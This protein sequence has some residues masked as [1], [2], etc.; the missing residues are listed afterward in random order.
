MNT[1]WSRPVVAAGV[2]ALLSALL[3]APAQAASPPLVPGESVGTDPDEEW[4]EGITIPTQGVLPDAE[5][6]PSLYTDAAGVAT[7]RARV[8]GEVP[9]PH[10]HYAMAWGRLVADAD[11]AADAGRVDPA[12][13]VKT[14]AA[15]ATGFAWL[16]TGEQEYLD[17]AAA[18]LAAAYDTIV[19]TDQYV[20]QQMTNYALA[21]DWVAADLSPEQDG[22]IRA[23]VKR[24]ADWLYDYLD[25]P[26][27]RSHNHRSKAGAALGS[28][29]LAFS[30]DPDA[31]AYLDRGLQNINRVFRYMFTKDGI[32]RDGAAYY[33]I[34][35]VINS[36]PFLWQYRNVSGVDLFP[37]LQ[38]AFEWQLTTINPKGLNPPLDDGWYKVTWLN[39]VAA[40][41]ADTPTALSDSGTLGELFQWQFFAS[42]LNAARYP[43]DWTGARDQFY[44]WP[45]EIALYDSTIAEVPPDGGSGTID[46]NA[47]P[48]GGDTI[49][50]SDWRMGDAGT[51]W[52]YFTGVAMSNNHDHADG[53]QLLIDGE[54]AILARDNGYGP[55]RFGGRD[56]W[57]GAEHHNVVTADGAAVGD[58][59]PTRGFLSGGGFGFAE[60]SATYWNDGAASHTRA[61]AFPGSDYFVVL[62]RMESATSK[63]WDGYW[64]VRGD[65]SGVANR[66]TWTTAPGPWGDA[67]RLHALTVPATAA[68][69]VVTDRFNPYGT[70]VDTGFEG[71]PD[72]S[73]DVE[74][75]T[76]LRVSQQGTSAQLLSVL[77]PSAV[78]TEAPR[79]ED[80]GDAD[81]LAARVSGDGYVDTVV[82]P[83]AGGSASA[84]GLAVAAG[85]GWARTT[86]GALAG[87]AVH[88]GL[89][90][91][92]QG[93]Q[94]GAASAPVTLAADVADP[95]RHVVEVAAVDGEVDLSLPASAGR[96]LL[97][98]TLDGTPV[99]AELSDGTVELT[100]AGG[101][102]LVLTYGAPA[103]APAPPVGLTA[104]GYAG[105]VALTWEPVPTA[106]SYRVLRNGRQIA[107]VDVPAYE[108]GDVTDGRTYS[109]SVLAVNEVGASRPSVAVPAEAGARLPA[110]PDGLIAAASHRLV[111][112]SWLPVRDAGSYQVLRAVGDDDLQPVVTGLTDT[113]WADTSVTNGIAYRYAVR[114]TNQVGTGELSDEVVAVPSTTPPDIPQ[115]LSASRAPGSVTLSWLEA[116]RADSYQVLRGG[117]TD[118]SL[119]VVADGVTESTWTDTDVTDGT[120]YTYRVL[121]TNDAGDSE[122]SRAVT[123]VPGCSLVHPVG[124]DGAVIEAEAYS[125]R[126][127][128]YQ[129]ADDLDRFGGRVSMVPRGSEYKNNPDL[130]GRYDLEVAEAGRYY[131]AVLGFG[132]SGSNDSVFISMDNSPPATVNLS[133]GDWFYRQSPIGFDLEAG[134]HTL[135]IKSRED[136]AMVDR[137]VAYPSASIPD[138]VRFSPAWTLP[139][140]PECGDGSGAPAAPEAVSSLVAE[141]VGDEVRL[142]W[143]G[144][145]LAASYTVLRDG[146]VVAEGVTVTGWTDPSP[147]SGSTQ[148]V[149]VA[150]NAVGDSPPSDPVT[151]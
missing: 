120:G 78:G 94:L 31:Q 25:S 3:F 101:G 1:Q 66:R 15:K 46:M 33:W 28:W 90:A 53:L 36:T 124:T 21:Y 63:A 128:E 82:A 65:M 12:D 72:P 129:L 130:W 105:A 41:Y 149:V 37:A 39:T 55:Q 98:A 26:G 116:A 113:G 107:Q 38:P 148:Y 112:L 114:A 54:N 2:L 138:D 91:A 60:K 61:V 86:G 20:A 4:W 133:V 56:E 136:G 22:E 122:P 106:T 145:R 48:R 93:A 70:G 139:D 52:G 23:A 11:E 108:D 111:E 18:N 67:A 13:D 40:A 62:D 84:G 110:A 103:T 69:S 19:P 88:D 34:F 14:K 29:A 92:W 144:S 151:G 131:V 17:A 96:P 126:S 47:G 137:F 109:Y 100:V 45:E 97:A 115:G 150:T 42:D 127:G 50:R 74:D 7:L 30:A 147:G 71:Y 140:T 59:T 8:G 58:P 27:V 141:R 57:K 121:A 68:T 125:G 134:F 49:F 75:T 73:T 81:V 79:L 32:Y 10:G 102:E 51:R 64:H 142:T 5:V 76:G 99:D 80:L 16:V 35:T 43:D 77:V 123:A 6:H 87:W 85:L 44:G 24:G 119:E 118:E 146:S 95:T 143:S 9:D 89:S 104:T 135:L 117:L 83:R 132:E